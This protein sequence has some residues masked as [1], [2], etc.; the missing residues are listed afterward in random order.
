MLIRTKLRHI[1]VLFFKDMGEKTPHL[2]RVIV[3]T[4]RK[5]YAACKGTVSQDFRFNFVWL[6]I[7]YMRSTSTF[8][9]SASPL[10]ALLK[11][12][13]LKMAFQSP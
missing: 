4:S 5:K 1:L 6:Q 9:V 3:K 12:K 13:N 2:N 10:L 8:H 11:L 7:F